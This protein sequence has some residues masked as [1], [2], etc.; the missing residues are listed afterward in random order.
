VYLWT[1]E[2][3]HSFLVWVL[4][5]IKGSVPS[6]SEAWREHQAAIPGFW[7]SK[8]VHTFYNLERWSSHKKA[9]TLTGT[10][11]HIQLN[12][13]NLLGAYITHIRTR[14]L[15][16][17]L[18]TTLC[19]FSR[20]ASETVRG[21]TFGQVVNPKNEPLHNQLAWHRLLKWHHQLLPGPMTGQGPWHRPWRHQI[22]VP[23]GLVDSARSSVTVTF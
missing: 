18:A 11:S 22:N 6:N 1:A 12:L 7:L 17:V 19:G 20:V 21:D 3:Y 16:L 10:E 14:T 9:N 4:Q 13:S 5:S 23:A 15:L 8:V 2:H